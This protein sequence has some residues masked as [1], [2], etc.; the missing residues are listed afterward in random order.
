M[1]NDEMLEEEDV[2]M[3]EDVYSI[4]NSFIE[5]ED[6]DTSPFGPLQH[7]LTAE[8]FYFG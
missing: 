6:M 8:I 3:E 1:N 2:R 5:D 7:S 4:L